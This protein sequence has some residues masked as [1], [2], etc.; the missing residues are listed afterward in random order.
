LN[1]LDDWKT[2]K[3]RIKNCIEKWGNKRQACKTKE[4]EMRNV[5]KESIRKGRCDEL[6]KTSLGMQTI[7]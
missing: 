1:K 5:D 3:W 2:D 7:F 4:K 6:T